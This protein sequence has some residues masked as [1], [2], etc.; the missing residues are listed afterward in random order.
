MQTIVGLASLCAALNVFQVDVLQVDLI[1]LGFSCYAVAKLGR[2]SDRRKSSGLPRT[3]NQLEVPVGAGPVLAMTWEAQVSSVLREIPP[4]VDDRIVKMV[5]A[6]I[7]TRV[8]DHVPSA[9]VLGTACEDRGRSNAKNGFVVPKV[10]IIIDAAPTA[11]AEFTGVK[12]QRTTAYGKQLDDWNLKKA[13]VRSLSKHLV[14]SEGFV[15]R[16][17]AFSAGDP[18]VTLFVPPRPGVWPY[19]FHVELVANTVV[20]LQSSALLR[21]VGCLDSRVTPLISLVRLWAKERGIC[22]VSLGFLSPYA[23]AL[24]TIF[25]MQVREPA[26]DSGEVEGDGALPDLESFI[27]AM[28]PSHRARDGRDVGEAVVA[29]ERSTTVAGVTPVGELFKHFLAFYDQE[30]DW[31]NELISVRFGKRRLP[32]LPTNLSKTGKY[33]ICMSIEDPFDTS[34]NLGR[35]LSPE[36]FARTKSEF[37]VAKSLCFSG[38]RLSAVLRTA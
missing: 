16:R 18:K 11:L 36:N 10:D 27:S 30:F 17:T 26:V 14:E 3:K 12:L 15:F 28:Q 5:V 9:S 1:L 32:P 38:A 7:L 13:T 20:P 29:M 19:G 4:P 24:M 23:W 2:H 6:A 25:F 31:S 34:K 22:H 8:Q 21:E 37:A 35:I 33:E